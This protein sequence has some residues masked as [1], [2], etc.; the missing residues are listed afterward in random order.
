[1]NVR[2]SAHVVLTWHPSRA[3]GDAEAFS[4]LTGERV[5]LTKALVAE[6]LAIPDGEFVARD[7]DW[8]EGLCH[9]GLLVSNSTD[10]RSTVLRRRDEALGELGWDFESAAFHFEKRLEG[11]RMTLAAPAESPVPALRDGPG[12]GQVHLPLVERDSEFYRV[13]L[14]RR[15]QREFDPNGEVTPGQLSVLLRYVWGAHAY[16]RND[17]GDPLLAK[18]SPSGGSLHPLEVYPLLL[19]VESRERGLYHYSVRSHALDVLEHLDAAAARD[20]AETFLAGQA[21]LTKAHVLFVL[22]ARFE[23]MHS[24]YRNNV[25]AYQALLIE[26]GH[27]SQT[28]YLVATELGLGP[29]VTSLVNHADI[30]RRLGLDPYREGALAICGCGVPA[31]DAPVLHPEPFV[32]RET[33]LDA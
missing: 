14:R 27:F 6:L 20:L 4:L 3:G 23:R 25:G 21:W 33:E 7:D 2:R 32:P 18:T 19:N 11:A 28:F 15:T 31:A 30:D 24:K 8:V 13:L 12:I 26:L 5:A 22:T 16:G 29:F 9:A 1:V 17:R 10:L